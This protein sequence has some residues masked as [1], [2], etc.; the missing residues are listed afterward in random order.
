MTGNYTMV[1]HLSEEQLKYL[2]DALYIILRMPNHLAFA[3]EHAAQ[4]NLWGLFKKVFGLFKEAGLTDKD[5][6]QFG[7][8]KQAVVSSECKRNIELKKEKA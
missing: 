7:P 8:V 2:V 1:L 6:E 5:V 4:N 3:D